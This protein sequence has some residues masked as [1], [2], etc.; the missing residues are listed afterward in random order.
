M[1]LPKSVKIDVV[2]RVL[3][4]H[5]DGELACRLLTSETTHSFDRMRVL[6]G[7]TLWEYW[8]GT[9]RDWAPK[10]RSHNHPMFGAVTAYLYDYLLG[11]RVS[12]KPDHTAKLEISPVLTSA[13]NRLKGSRVVD[14]VRVAVAYTREEGKTALTVTLSE[15]IDA[16]LTWSGES[17]A[18]AKGENRFDFSFPEKEI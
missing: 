5:G 8:P 16:T 12:R 11:I 10:D 7:T 6:G 17:Y 3:F 18:L 2:T 9:I 4:E 13:V 1:L 15:A 14:G